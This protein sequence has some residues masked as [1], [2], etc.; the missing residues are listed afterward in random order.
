M[1]MNR[2]QNPCVKNPDYNFAL[3]IERSIATKAGCNPH[4]NQFNVNDEVEL[5]I[6]EN[7]SMLE[8]YG[9]INIELGSRPRNDLVKTSGCLM[10]CSFMEYTVSV[11]RK[12]R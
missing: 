8:Q 6:C 5:P 9:W 12:T 10:P 1:K 11:M 2:P 7:A 3:C 4:W